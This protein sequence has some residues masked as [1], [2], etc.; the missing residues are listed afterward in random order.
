MNLRTFENYSVIILG[1]FV[2]HDVSMYISKANTYALK[3]IVVSVTND[4]VIDQRVSRICDSL[5]KAGFDIT[6][7]GRKLKDSPPIKKPYKTCRFKLI[8]N[9]GP[10]FYAEFN[11]RL[12]FYLLF[13]K[14]D[15]YLS[16]DLDTLP[17]NYYAS[18]IRR[19]KLVYDS[20]EFFTE[21]PEVINR[22][23][24]KSFWQSIENSIMPHILFSYTVCKLIAY[25]Y[26]NKYG[27]NMEVLRNLPLRKSINKNEVQDEV[28]PRKIIIY[29]G[30][31]NIGRGI[32]LVIEAMQYIEGAEF[33]IV[34]TGYM[35]NELK[36]IVIRKGLTNK[37]YFKGRIPFE[38]L[39]KI[40]MQTHLGVSLEENLGLN[41]YYALPNKL[42][43]YIQAEVPVLTSDFPEMSKIVNS[44]EIGTTIS[45]RDPKNVASV[46]INM[47]NNEKQRSFW[48][49]NLKKA[50]SE[51][52]WE[53][54][55]K[56]L[57]DFYMKII[58]D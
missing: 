7:I 52:C 45:N 50:A 2:N 30:A 22:K 37:I 19:K 21:L 58:N 34:G 28:Y 13:L 31:L 33:W 25:T 9:K 35:E 55:E 15:I 51:L 27:I 36:K 18:I 20:H 23:F 46:I 29:Q 26:N 17:A 38:E 48:K 41:Y 39:Y 10:F 11:I 1:F 16:N 8:F 6:L 42:F 44:Y 32:E 4:L 47:L 12:F 14:T 24:V 56:K 57:L 40:T 54:E 5:M 43:D 3:K 53:N 49:T